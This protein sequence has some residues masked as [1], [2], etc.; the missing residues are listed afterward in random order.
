MIDV[1][2]DA[3]AE[4]ATMRGNPE[5]Y[6]GED[7][8]ETTLMEDVEELQTLLD[9]CQC[10]MLSIKQNHHTR[11][12]NHAERLISEAFDYVTDFYERGI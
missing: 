2:V 7:E 12:L 11:R 9:E 1:N 5:F 4:A 10:K 3:L 8:P 6:E